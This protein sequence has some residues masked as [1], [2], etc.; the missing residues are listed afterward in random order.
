MKPSKV[1]T[2]SPQ[3]QTTLQ[4]SIPPKPLDSNPSSNGSHFPT[5]LFYEPTSVLDP[6]LSSSPAAA[7]TTGGPDLA[8]LPWDSHNH[9][10]HH[11]LHPPPQPPPSEEWDLTSWFLAEKDDLSPFPKAPH[12]S[13]FHFPEDDNPSN[14]SLFDGPFD[15]PDSF[16]P[17]PPFSDTAVAVVSPPPAFDRTQ[18]ELLLQAALSIESS[19]IQTAHTIL[20]RLNQYLPASAGSPLQRAA[21]HFKEALLALLPLPDRPA[22][23]PPLSAVEIVRRISAHKAFSDFSPVPQFASFTA[24]QILLDALDAANA[25]AGGGGHRS[26]HLIDFEIGL[27]GQWSSFAQEVASRSRAARAPPPGLRITAVVPE[28]T[29]ETALAAENLRDFARG[30]GVR[31]TVD[32]IRVG[33]LGTLALNGIRLAPGEPVAVVLTPAIFRLLGAAP[34]SSA[35]LL[36]FVRRAS[37]RVVVFVDTEWSYFGD[38]AGHPPS[39]RRTVA[40]GIEHYAAVLESVEAAAVVSGATGP[41]EETVRR[42]ERTVVRPRIFSAVGSWRSGRGGGWR[43][44]FAG[45]GIAP[46]GFSEFAESQAEWLVRGAQVD[47]YHVARREGSMVLSWR[48]RELASTS[49]WRC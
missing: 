31:L 27:G 9:Q 4:Y 30:L 45:A 20:A 28:E 46:V 35:S 21:F 40:G 32:F 1:L 12:H 13:Q 42:V 22:A 41:V 10:H 18:L 8:H 16:E 7:A 36:R 34:E 5:N 49:A 25:A 43:E 2:D 47:G 14:A 29:G 48:G 38:C 33:G 6:H 11:L 3:S 15:L 24:N 26:V 17:L 39:L 19:D 44:A 37:P 23:E